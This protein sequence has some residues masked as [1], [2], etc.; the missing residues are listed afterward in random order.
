MRW[1]LA[2]LLAPADAP[3]SRRGPHHRGLH[4]ESLEDRL[5]PAGL[6]LAYLAGRYERD[7]STLWVNRGF[8]VA[9]PPSR[10]GA[11]PEVTRIVLIGA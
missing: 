6:F 10:V 7:G 9:G 1:S 3:R 4:L 2:S 8:G 5:T 11:P